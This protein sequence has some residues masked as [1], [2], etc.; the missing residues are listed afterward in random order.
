MR[1]VIGILFLWSHAALSQS[2]TTLTFGYYP[3]M[4]QVIQVSTEHGNVAI[5]RLTNG[6]DPV[7]KEI[8]MLEERESKALQRR[9]TTE[10]KKLWARDFT[11]DI[12]ANKVVA[13]KT[14]LAYYELYMRIVEHVD[15]RDDKVYSNGTEF[16]RAMDD[17]TKTIKEVHKKYMH[18]WQ[19]G[20]GGWKLISKFGYELKK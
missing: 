5:S 12:P 19:N 7:V 8:Q 2:D 16:I 1:C 20:L 9:D 17:R 4:Q 14:G 11:A 10:L 15:V 18:V 13:D 3:D 6:A